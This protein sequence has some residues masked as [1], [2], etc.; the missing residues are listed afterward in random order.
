MRYLL[1]VI[2]AAAAPVALAL[3]DSPA[4]KVPLAEHAGIVQEG[5]PKPVLTYPRYWSTQTK[6]IV[7]AE[8]VAMSADLGITCRNLSTGGREYWW[9]VQSCAG[10]VGVQ[11][12]IFGAAQGVAWVLHRTGHPRLAQIP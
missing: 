5:P 10:M 2:L 6:W 1:P 11:L 8:F 12:G 9:P 7:G 4:P 3:P